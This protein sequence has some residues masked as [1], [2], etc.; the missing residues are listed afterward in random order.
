MQ[1]IRKTSPP[2][3]YSIAF[4]IS[5]IVGQVLVFLGY[6]IIGIA[7]TT[8]MFIVWG[9]KTDLFHPDELDELND[10]TCM[11]DLYQG[12]SERNRP[13]NGNMLNH[14]KDGENDNL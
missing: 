13:I 8:I 4:V 2:N 10:G 3:P 11:D 7:L 5:I 6:K 9:W 12:P 14:Q 1:S